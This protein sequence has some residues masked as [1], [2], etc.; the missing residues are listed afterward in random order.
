MAKIPVKACWRV[1]LYAVKGSVLPVNGCQWR[2][3]CI[4]IERSGHGS[5]F[6]PVITD[7]EACI[8]CLA[9]RTNGDQI[10]QIEPSE[11]F[12][13]GDKQLAKEVRN[14]VG[15]HMS[16]QERWACLR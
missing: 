7:E 1:R 4:L 2:F 15:Q 16:W 12:L 10:N 5:R 6:F 8:G 9:T 3:A 13:T 11:S 14:E